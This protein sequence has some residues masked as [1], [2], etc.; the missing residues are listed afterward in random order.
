M[1]CGSDDVH[2]HRIQQMIVV[3]ANRED[4]EET[5]DRIVD[6]P[7]RPDFI[8]CQIATRGSESHNGRQADRQNHPPESIHRHLAIRCLS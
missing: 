2:H 7:Q 5:P 4:L 1:P 8:K 3:M 6:E